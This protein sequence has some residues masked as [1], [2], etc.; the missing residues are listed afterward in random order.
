MMNKMLN[1]RAEV[2][3]LL[4][5]LSLM[6]GCDPEEKV[7]GR[8]VSFGIALEGLPDSVSVFQ[9]LEQ[10]TGF[11]VSLINFFLQWPQ[12]P[13]VDNFPGYT[14]EAVHEFGAVPVLT[15]EP[16]YYEDNVEYMIPAQDILEGRYD[17]YITLFADRMSKL[18]RPVIIRLAHEM[19]LS[20]YHWGGT[21]EQ[22]GP[23]SPAR[24]VR[25]FRHVV[26]IFRGQGT[27]NVLFAFCP[28]NE[29]QPDPDVDPDADWNR[30]RNYYPGD[31]YVDVL[32][33]DGYN[34]G[35]TRTVAEHGWNSRWQSF[36][37][38]FRDI[39]QELRAI[40]ADMPL[41]VFETSSV[42]QGGD[43]NAWIKNAVLTAGKW[44]LEGL[45][46]FHVDKEE[47]WRMIGFRDSEYFSEI[48]K[49]LPDQENDWL[50]PDP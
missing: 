46:W 11:P 36:E 42:R 31:E 30:A 29:S 23:E 15:W 44:G 50:P 14:I 39:Y 10:E 6:I 9:E 1:S 49:I 26:Q 43:R 27:Q 22:Y 35:T 5:F 16:M 17:G 8:D 3:L 2:L 13:G 25:M 24:Y 28:N 45:V 7:E 37:E 21:L 18:D 38:T 4:I 40:N 12:D 19:N 33:M 48:R 20:R 47:D 34:W 32:G 41:Y